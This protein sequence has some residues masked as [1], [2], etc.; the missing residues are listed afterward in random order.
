MLGAGSFLNDTNLK[1]EVL[2]VNLNSSIKER[3]Q[4]AKELRL[5]KENYQELYDQIVQEQQTESEISTQVNN[6]AKDLGDVR[7]NQK[8]LNAELSSR[9]QELKEQ[10]KNI[11]QL[12]NKL[13][14]RSRKIEELNRITQ[15]TLYPGFYQDIELLENVSGN[16]ITT[17]LDSR[18]A[19]T[20]INGQYTDQSKTEE[21]IHRQKAVLESISIQLQQGLS[22]K[23]FPL[24]NGSVLF[25]VDKNRLF[26][27]E[28]FEFSDSGIKIVRL[29]EAAF[30]EFPSHTLQIVSFENSAMQFSGQ[31]VQT[32]L[33]ERRVMLIATQFEPALNNIVYAFG[34]NANAKNGVIYFHLIPQINLP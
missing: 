6:L 30:N 28:S 33:S 26:D 24:L 2:S 23:V 34:F 3:S 16:W 7:A 17:Y 21:L 15:A 22:G 13:S 31:H 20:R 18:I 12:Q 29:L 27:D 1:L 11:E 4:L 9:T 19:I 14:N 10:N 25:Q 32:D 5:S 8:Q